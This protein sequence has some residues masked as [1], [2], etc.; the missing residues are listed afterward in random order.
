MFR[1]YAGK[2]NK[3]ADYSADNIPYTPKKSL[4]ISLDGVKEND[5]TMV[6][7]FPGR[8]TQYLHS[9]AVE[10]IMTVN[11]PAKIAIREKALAVIDGFMRKDEQKF[12]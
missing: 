10:Q 8:T 7:G 2:D 11:D 6:F 1:I 3:P 4:S 12:V 5:F 9:A